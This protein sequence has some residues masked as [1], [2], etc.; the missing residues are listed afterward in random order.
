[1]KVEVAV[2]FLGYCGLLCDCMSYSWSVVSN[3][4]V[5]PWRTSACVYI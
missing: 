4:V 3:D 1:M 5:L 2:L